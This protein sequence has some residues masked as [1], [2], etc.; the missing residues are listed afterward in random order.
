MPGSSAS[1]CVSDFTILTFWA[2]AKGEAASATARIIHPTHLRL[3]VIN[4]S[5]GCY[6]QLMSFAEG[7]ATPP[8]SDLTDLATSTTR[9]AHMNPMRARLAALH[10]AAIGL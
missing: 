7:T 6:P 9:C 3:L 5:L 2:W 10:M 4:S 1:I 8:A